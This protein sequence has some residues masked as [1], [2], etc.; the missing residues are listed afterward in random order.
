MT[1]IRKGR[2]IELTPEELYEAYLEQENRFL[3]CDAAN[4]LCDYIGYTGAS[5]EDPKTQRRI[6]AEFKKNYGISLSDVLKAKPGPGYELLR[7]AA[8]AFRK[9]KNA[10]TGEL[11]IWHRAIETVLKR[12]KLP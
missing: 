7:E 8:A 10:E 12:R 2:Q 4:R 11:E 6:A 3:I 5:S 9:I 1:I